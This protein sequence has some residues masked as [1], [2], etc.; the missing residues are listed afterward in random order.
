MYTCTK[1]T[2]EVRSIVC[3]ASHGWPGPADHIG[4]NTQFFFVIDVSQVVLVECGGPAEA[5]RRLP[6]SHC[7]MCIC[8]LAEL[9]RLRGGFA[10][11]CVHYKHQS[12]RAAE[13]CGGHRGGFAE[14]S[15]N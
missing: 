4:L 2:R 13:A 11:A 14:A 8:V 7:A 15:S 1:H 6:R 5:L 10:E 9:R 3:M 12:H